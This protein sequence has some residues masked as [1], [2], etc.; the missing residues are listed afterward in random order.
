MKISIK[1]LQDGVHSYDFCESVT[2]CGLAHHPNLR[3]DAEILVEMEKR[4]SHFFVNTRVRATGYFVCDRCLEGFDMGV[5]EQSRVIFSSDPDMLAVAG[6]E[7]RV[8]AKDANEIDI[9]DD[10]RD[11]L[12]LALPFKALCRPEC[13]GWCSHCGVNL[14]EEKCRCGPHARDARWAGLD[15]FLEKS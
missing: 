4:S 2:A 1:H 5:E 12:L 11:A 7:I 9:S 3:T 15:R 10:V 6:A 13:R 8:I 14:N